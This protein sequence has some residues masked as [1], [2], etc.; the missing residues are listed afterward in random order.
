MS[1]E[2]ILI[3]IKKLLGITKEYE[4]FDAD[5]VMHINTVLATLHQLGVGPK[6]GFAIEDD[7]AE[8]S[9]FMGD[10]PRLNL[11]KSYVYLKTKLLFD[12]PLGSAV[13]GSYEKQISELEWRILNVTDFPENTE[14][15]ATNE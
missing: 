6:E 10:D 12:P 9:G 1:S 11:V 3:S 2:S 4:H 5:L 8:W 7:L 15:E 14:E 13:L